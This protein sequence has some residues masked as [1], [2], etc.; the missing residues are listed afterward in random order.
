MSKTLLRWLDASIGF[1]RAVNRGMR[2]PQHLRR[3]SAP[4]LLEKGQEAMSQSGCCCW[5]LGLFGRSS[6]VFISVKRHRITRHYLFQ[7][8]LE[9]LSF[10]CLSRDEQSHLSVRW[11]TVMN[12]VSWEHRV[13]KKYSD[14]PVYPHEPAGLDTKSKFQPDKELHAITKR[15]RHRPSNT[16]YQTR[17]RMQR[18]SFTSS[19]TRTGLESGVYGG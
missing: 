15:P 14:G 19:N 18:D 13:N 11:R 4:G 3:V 9:L 6:S 12:W 8:T 5:R 7:V 16:E 2:V 10:T 17:H 1:Q